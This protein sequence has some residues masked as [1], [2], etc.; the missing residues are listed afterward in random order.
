VRLAK[1]CRIDAQFKA[2]AREDPDLAALRAA[3]AVG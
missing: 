1:A 3:D 2:A